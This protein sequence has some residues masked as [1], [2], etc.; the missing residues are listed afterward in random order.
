MNSSDAG[1]P[2]VQKIHQLLAAKDDT[3]RF[4]GLVLLKTTLDNHASD[5]KQEEVRGLW[6][7]ISPRFLDR[8]IRTGSRPGSEHRKQAGDMLDV[9][10]A[11]IYTFTKLL[12]DCA[13]NEKFYGRIPILLDAVLYRWVGIPS[14]SLLSYAY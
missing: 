9:A 2:E 4:V 3:S 14:I 5:L 12:N 8:L 1:T 13:L 6:D 7:S 11:V 10:V